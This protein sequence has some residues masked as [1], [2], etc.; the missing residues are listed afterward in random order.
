MGILIVSGIIFVV[1]IVVEFFSENEWDSDF[2]SI[3]SIAT[4]VVSGF[5]FF[6]VGMIGLVGVFCEVDNQTEKEV[7]RMTII[8][9]LENIDSDTPIEVIVDTYD[10]AVTFNAL[11]ERSHKK[12]GNFWTG[13][14]YTDYSMIDPINIEEYW[15]GFEDRK[16]E[17]DNE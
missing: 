11:I 5:V 15:N 6:I 17:I 7:Q 16:E 8:Y 1:G 4:I 13:F 10:E 12:Y 2:L 14:L 3:V 9:D